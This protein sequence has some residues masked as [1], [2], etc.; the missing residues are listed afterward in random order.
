[1][2]RRHYKFLVSIGLQL[3]TITVCLSNLV[4]APL[5]TTI[6]KDMNTSISAAGM[7]S[8]VT[9]FATAV[10]LLCANVL[11]RRLK[12]KQIVAIALSICVISNFFLSTATVFGIVLMGR[13][14]TGI[15]LG[16]I[17]FATVDLITRWL[18]DKERSYYIAIQTVASTMCGFLISRLAVP[19][20]YLLKNGW[21]SVFA[22]MGF[23]GIGALGL[24]LYIGRREPQMICV[25]NSKPA[26]LSPKMLRQV[27]RRRDV[28]F[29]S[30]YMALFSC[31]NVAV[32][33][34]LA[35]YLEIGH[36]L[37]LTKATAFL[38]Y[39]SLAGMLGGPSASI[40]S[41]RLGKRKPVLLIGAAG[42]AIGLLLVI[43]QRW[44][45]LLVLS[46]FTLGF[47]VAFSVPLI[48]IITTE[49]PN[50]TPEVAS[51]TYSVVYAVGYFATIFTPA[52]LTAVM[53][54][55]TMRAGMN[56]FV[57]IFFVSFAVIFM[58]RETGPAHQLAEA[59]ALNVDLKENRTE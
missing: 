37:P 25:Q 57:G 34:Y 10:T 13:A 8:S 36:G 21:R 49:L 23:F 59:Q 44:E 42:A 31:A 40:L 55:M 26:K 32:T 51:T 48:Q 9:F 6:A 56:V 11:Q 12:A 41:T 29:L 35:A 18:S 27:L 46:I 1:M 17:S 47:F 45:P 2:N 54:T 28:L 5:L 43:N 20:M 33:T 15:A 4:L 14:L 53:G 7:A 24:W 19:L 38:G 50:T 58:L 30:L 16:A 39:V 3:S 52:I 22:V